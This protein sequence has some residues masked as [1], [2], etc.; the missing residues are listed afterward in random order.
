[1]P[2]T[3][4]ACSRFGAI[5]AL[6]LDAA[7]AMISPSVDIRTPLGVCI[8]GDAYRD[9]SSG[10]HG[11]SPDLRHR[12]AGIVAKQ[13]PTLVFE[14]RVTDTFVGRLKTPAGDVPLTGR[15]IELPTGDLWRFRWR[16]HRQISPLSSTSTSSSVRSD[17]HSL[18]FMG[19]S[20]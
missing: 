9:W 4:K 3:D 10:L 17:R 19:R 1:M 16:P 12:I 13:G 6:D 20:G 18:D 15:A 5:N 7:V 2:L 8:G 14:S 11:A